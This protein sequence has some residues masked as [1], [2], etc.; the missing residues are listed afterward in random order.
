MVPF[1]VASRELV[2]PPSPK[3]F[4]SLIIKRGKSGF[5]SDS[6]R[7]GKSLLFGRSLKISVVKVSCSLSPRLA[8][9]PANNIETMDSPI[10]ASHEF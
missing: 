8:V 6:T 4:V 7:L 1:F 5:F 3:E 2:I 9:N 10:R